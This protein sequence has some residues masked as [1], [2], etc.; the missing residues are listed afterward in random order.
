MAQLMPLTHFC[1]LSKIHIGFTFLLLAHPGSPEK[2][3]VKCV[4]VCTVAE[5][6]FSGCQVSILVHI[7]LICLSAAI[8]DY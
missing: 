1:C 4:C 3:S 7:K 5:L 6:T 2:R 8:T